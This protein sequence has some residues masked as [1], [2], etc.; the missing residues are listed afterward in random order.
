MQ[1]VPFRHVEELKGRCI[2]FAEAYGSFLY[3]GNIPPSLKDDIHRLEQQQ[4]QTTEI[5]TLRLVKFTHQ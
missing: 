3:S 1:H 5:L 4:N 2:T